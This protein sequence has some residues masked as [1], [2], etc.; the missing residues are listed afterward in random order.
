MYCILKLVFKSKWISSYKTLSFFFFNSVA[1]VC[2]QLLE[3]NNGYMNCSSEEPTFGTVCTF[4][5]LDGHQLIRDEIMT[6]NLNGSWSGEVAV[7]QGKQ[8]TMIVVECRFVISVMKW[9][10]H[11]KAFLLSVFSAH[12]DPSASLIKVTE[13]TLG[14]AGIISSSGLFLVYWIQKR[15]RSKGE[16]FFLIATFDPVFHM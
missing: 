6:C 16:S 9:E 5:C 8:L 10:R 14:V 4:S 12:P 11:S 3:P 15:L 1:V 7:C 2:P 13:V